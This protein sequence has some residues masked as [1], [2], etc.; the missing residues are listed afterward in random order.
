MTRKNNIQ[1]SIIK[2]LKFI[3][4]KYNLRFWIFGGW[5]IDEL[6]KKITRK[7][8]DI[9]LVINLSDRELFKINN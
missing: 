5:G 6:L 1:F 9:D 3:G 2:E 7:H 8:A 4:D